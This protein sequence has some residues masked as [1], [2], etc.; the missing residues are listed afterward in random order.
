MKKFLACVAFLVASAW[1]NPSVLGTQLQFEDGYLSIDTTKSCNVDTT[2]INCSLEKGLAYYSTLD[3][4]YAVFFEPSAAK[5]QIF[6]Y[7]SS[8]ENLFAKNILDQV[9]RYEFLKWVE[10]G[11]VKMPKDSALHL[12][13][14]ILG[15]DGSEIGGLSIG[16]KKVCDVD[17]SQCRAVRVWGGGASAKIP[18]ENIARLPK[19]KVLQNAES[20][21]PGTTS[22]P[23]D[24]RL[25][26][27]SM[28]K[29]PPGTGFKAFDMNG[30]YLYRGS[31][32]GV[33]KFQGRAV[34]LKFENGRTA[35]FR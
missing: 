9:L 13:D 33:S 7:P 16:Y 17:P 11:I 1:S 15:A 28:G 30:I 19:K 29:I 18:E 4:G 2:Y 21:N 20:V 23:Q 34:I 32:L 27:Q 24:S 35:V 6:K 14:W 22:L 25:S 12:M 26:P 31:W 8:E 5:I 10:W 3:T